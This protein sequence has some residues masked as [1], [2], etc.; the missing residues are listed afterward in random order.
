MTWAIIAFLYVS[1][2]AGTFAIIASDG[3]DNL[4]RFRAFI[5]VAFWPLTIWV[6][7]IA[8]LAERIK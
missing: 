3:F 7:A 4:H 1:G 8:S 5:A 2:A 6:F